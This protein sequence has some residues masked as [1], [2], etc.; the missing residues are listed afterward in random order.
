MSGKRTDTPSVAAADGAPVSSTAANNRSPTLTALG[1]PRHTP[2][3]YAL[4]RA[5]TVSAAPPLPTVPIGDATHLHHE[6]IAHPAIAPAP[7]GFV[8][9]PQ[10]RNHPCPSRAPPSPTVARRER[11]NGTGI[12]LGCQMCIMVLPLFTHLLCSILVSL[13]RTYLSWSSHPPGLLLLVLRLCSLLGTCSSALRSRHRHTSFRRCSH[14]VHLCS[15]IL[16]ERVSE[17]VAHPP[18]GSPTHLSE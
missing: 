2:G 14:N 3:T 15:R 12:Y 16:R 7:H 4:G 17:R 5:R 10:F 18:S 11:I 13:R 1:R 9:Q 6:Q 8:A